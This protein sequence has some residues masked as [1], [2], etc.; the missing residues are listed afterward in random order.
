[1]SDRVPRVSKVSAC[2]SM[3]AG[4]HCKAR[5][6][7]GQRPGRELLGLILDQ[8]RQVRS[9]CHEFGRVGFVSMRLKPEHAVIQV[10]DLGSLVSICLAVGPV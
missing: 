6:E 7:C 2:Y 3:P 4:A 8:K 1:M 5:A 10:G 9:I